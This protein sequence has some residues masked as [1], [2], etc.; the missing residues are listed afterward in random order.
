[1]YGDNYYGGAPYGTP[2]GGV[3][4]AILRGAKWIVLTTKRYITSIINTRVPFVNS[5]LQRKADTHTINSQGTLKNYL[6][7]K[8]DKTI[9]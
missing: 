6:T 1:M 4:E 8:K 7:T 3:V 2:A 5:L 9:L